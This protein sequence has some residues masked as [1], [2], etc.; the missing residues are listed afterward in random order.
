MY[1]TSLVGLCELA[2]SLVSLKYANRNIRNSKHF[3]LLNISLIKGDILENMKDFNFTLNYNLT[4]NIN[5]ILAFSR[6]L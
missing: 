2:A 4:V 6:A 3:V 5:S 1:A